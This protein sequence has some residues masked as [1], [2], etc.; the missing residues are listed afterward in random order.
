MDSSSVFSGEL[1]PSESRKIPLE[2]IVAA[3]GAKAERS[4][5]KAQDW[6]SPLL[7]CYRFTRWRQ[8]RAICQLLANLIGVFEAGARF[9]YPH[10]E[11]IGLGGSWEERFTTKLPLVSWGK[12]IP[13][14]E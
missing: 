3:T 8:T 12:N 14:R 1:A 9:F 2:F 7:T 4:F 13:T 10:G 6:L 5:C 11:C